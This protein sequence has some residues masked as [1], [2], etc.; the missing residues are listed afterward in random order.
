MSPLE[1]YTRRLFS[2]I[3]VLDFSARWPTF[4][5]NLIFFPVSKTQILLKWINSMV[6]C[7]LTPQSLSRDYVI[8]CIQCTAPG[9]A[10]VSLW[11]SSTCLC[12]HHFIGWRSHSSLIPLCNQ[13]CKYEFKWAVSLY[14]WNMHCAQFSLWSIENFM[15]YFISYETSM[16]MALEKLATICQ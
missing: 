3:I 14:W 9:L 12:L 8:A 5:N 13:S 15:W 4:E 2:V 6:D 1:C 16:W 11:H 7:L 10:P